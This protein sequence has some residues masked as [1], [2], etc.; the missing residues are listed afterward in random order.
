MEKSLR[1]VL[2]MRR[3][4]V[5]CAM[6][7]SACGGGGSDEVS[8]SPSASSRDA[9]KESILKAGDQ[10]ATGIGVLVT[11]PPRDLS[12][13]GTPSCDINPGGPRDLRKLLIKDDGKVVTYALE[14]GTFCMP[15][16]IAYIDNYMAFD[17][18][19]N[20]GTG[21]LGVG[22]LGTDLTLRLAIHPDL[23]V[24]AALYSYPPDCGEV[25]F[26]VATPITASLFIGPAGQ[27]I[28]VGDIP[29]SVFPGPSVKIDTFADQLPASFIYT[30][31]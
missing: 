24:E 20:T 19:L 4:A 1:G 12:L 7:L 30:F 9:A 6:L 25:A 17:T 13:A 5:T 14:Y 22:D 23:S 10:H 15:S 3:A 11:D 27:T 21:C 8:V 18:D 29:R 31:Q 28:L 2:C 26:P 16:G